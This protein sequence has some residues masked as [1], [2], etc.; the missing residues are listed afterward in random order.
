MDR[1]Q[2]KPNTNNNNK[3][4]N[5]TNKLDQSWMLIWI[6]QYFNKAKLCPVM[7]INLFHEME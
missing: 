1:M 6:M 3:N 2:D 7:Q 5:N 4:N